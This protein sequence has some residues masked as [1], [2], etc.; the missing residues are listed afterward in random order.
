MLV[1]EIKENNSHFSS[2]CH[3][4]QNMTVVLQLHSEFILYCDLSNFYFDTFLALRFWEI[5]GIKTYPSNMFFA[6]LRPKQ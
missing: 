6:M 5:S 2:N 3:S 1:S 4:T